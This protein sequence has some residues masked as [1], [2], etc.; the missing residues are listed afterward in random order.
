MML[1][2]CHS[3]SSSTCPKRR[4]KTP[5]SGCGLVTVL[6]SCFASGCAGKQPAAPENPPQAPVALATPQELKF[7][8]WPKFPG[9]T[10][11]LPN[12]SAR[13]SAAVEGRVVWLLH[14]PAAKDS[15]ALA[16]G[17]RVENGQIIGRLDDRIARAK[18][19]SIE[20]T[21]AETKEQKNQA[22]LAVQAANIEVDRLQ[23]LLSAMNG[24]DLPLT[25]RIE[26]DKA[27]IAQ[28]TAESKQK[29]MLEKLKGIEEEIKAA[30]QMLDFYVLRAPIAGR[31]GPIQAV[32][33]QTLAV[34]ATVAEIV[35]LDA[36]D[37]LCFVPPYTAAKL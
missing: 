3:A 15:P 30:D 32:P 16:E 11:P 33:G 26:L 22:D 7:G 36:I 13:V 31:L 18:R 37:V 10:Q 29:E 20:T 6:F 17:Q 2:L 24:R 9:A 35:D 5:Y 21:L 28:K 19:D 23:S 12:H 34:G 14:D 27:R 8:D 1:L 25:N 4:R